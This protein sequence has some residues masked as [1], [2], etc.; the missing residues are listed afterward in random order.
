MP[1]RRGWG[2]VSRD[3]QGKGPPPV[4]CE[5]RTD[6]GDLFITPLDRF[7]PTIRPPNAILCTETKNFSIFFASPRSRYECGQI[8]FF[9]FALLPPWVDLFRFFT[10][11]S[12]RPRSSRSGA[13]PRPPAPCGRARPAPASVGFADLARG[14]DGVQRYMTTVTSLVVG[15]TNG[16]SFF[17]RCDSRRSTPGGCFPQRSLPE[18]DRV[19]LDN[20]GDFAEPFPPPLR[21]LLWTRRS[22][23][24]RAPQRAARPLI[25]GRARPAP[26]LRRLLWRLMA[27]ASR[28]ILQ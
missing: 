27:Y 4:R 1:P 23:L 6:G 3:R 21:D 16:A 15:N 26:A 19:R 20:A 7:H 11:T 22:S 9:I 8:K 14:D 25:P 5:G 24:G 2:A 17:V 10:T 13:A 12:A 18:T 28:A